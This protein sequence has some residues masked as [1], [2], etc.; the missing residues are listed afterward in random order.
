ME[1]TAL[2]Q[3]MRAKNILIIDTQQIIETITINSNVKFNNK[4]TIIH[5]LVVFI[6]RTRGGLDQSS[7]GW[8]PFGGRP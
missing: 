2:N 8:P 4:N 3:I 5:L 7:G 6:N 1:C